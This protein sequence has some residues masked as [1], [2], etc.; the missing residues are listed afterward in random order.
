MEEAGSGGMRGSSRRGFTGAAG[1]QKVEIKRCKERDDRL[2]VG[3]TFPQLSLGE[4]H[5]AGKRNTSLLSPSGKLP[6]EAGGS[7]H[8]WWHTSVSRWP[9]MQQG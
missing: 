7:H 3:T 1:K 6:L 5:C 4:G 8:G 2:T 9:R